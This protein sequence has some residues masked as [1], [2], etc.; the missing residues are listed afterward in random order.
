MLPSLDSKP[1]AK[2]RAVDLFSIAA[3]S[4]PDYMSSTKLSH[5]FLPQSA[6]NGPE[7]VNIGA[8]RSS[9]PWSPLTSITL[10]L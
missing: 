2:A 3:T 7:L 1:F 5:N 10:P 4:G 9:N 8:D 6:V